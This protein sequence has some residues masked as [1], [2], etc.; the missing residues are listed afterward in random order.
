MT[1]AAASVSAQAPPVAHAIGG[2][3]GS[4]ISLFLAYPLERARI[5]LQSGASLP[6]KNNSLNSVE[7]E[8][9]GFP[10]NHQGPISPSPRTDSSC[11][12]LHQNEEK[13]KESSKEETETTPNNQKI[14]SST[15]INPT[16]DPSSATTSATKKRKE[17]L[18]ECL[19]R[20]HQRK[21]LYTGVSPVVSTIFTSQFIFFYMHAVVKKLFNQSSRGGSKRNAAAV[22][23]LSSCIAGLGNVLLTNPLWVV[24]MAIVTGETKSQNLWRELYVMIQKKGL[25]HMWS[26]TSA[27][28]LLVSNPVIQFFCY[29]QMKAARLTSP[30][31]SILPPIEAFF[32]GAMAKGVATVTT[33]PLQLAQTVMRL[34][35]KHKGTLDCLRKLYADGGFR[36]LFIGMR[37]KLLQTV[38]TAA[39]TFLT[40]EQILG[41]VQATL[42]SAVGKNDSTVPVP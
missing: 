17:T 24:N 40:Y 2:S 35:H 37:A 42:I 8:I 5:D 13:N 4:A 33:Y 3:L 15:P 20:L 32:I 28:V 29:E 11:V 7:D 38:L 18:F 14:S 12:S 10:T 22:S 39:F 19:M 1:T 30:N 36:K 16:I 26:G 27:S 23:L 34:E 9:D 31:K 25:R 6:T 41:V 21:E